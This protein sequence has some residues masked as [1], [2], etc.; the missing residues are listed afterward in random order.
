ME[1]PFRALGLDACSTLARSLAPNACSFLPITHMLPMGRSPL[2]RLLHAIA[3]SAFL[4][5][6][7]FIAPLLFI[8]LRILLALSFL[9]G[10]R[11]S[12]SRR[13]F[14][15]VTIAGVS[16]TSV[17]SVNITDIQ[18]AVALF[19]MA[20]SWLTLLLIVV[21][22]IVLSPG[23]LLQIPGDNQPIEFR[24][25]RTSLASVLVHAVVFFILLLLIDEYYF[26]SA[27]GGGGGGKHD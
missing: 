15:S 13:R 6:T 16:V 27:A 11:R 24:N 17:T 4:L 8:P 22:F 20:F 14:R 25:W 10:S 7:P 26:S 3:A 19:T 18:G 21:L 23:L 5:V 12:A 9:F 2:P 1:I